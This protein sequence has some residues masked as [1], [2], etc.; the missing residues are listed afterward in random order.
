MTKYS[1]TK[2]N[3]EK[4]SIWQNI[5][6]ELRDSIE[7]YNDIKIS[8]TGIPLFLDLIIVITICRTYSNLMN[9]KVLTAEK[10]LE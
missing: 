6:S 2:L 1:P 9:R 3:S 4:D 7:K 10:I 8:S 5:D